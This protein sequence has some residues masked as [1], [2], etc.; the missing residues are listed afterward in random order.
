M[1]LWRWGESDSV[2]VFFAVLIAVGRAFGRTET[3]GRWWSANPEP[4]KEYEWESSTVEVASAK[5]GEGDYGNMSMCIQR[6]A[7]P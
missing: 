1:P 4:E 5:H 6:V 7:L 3:N 2:A